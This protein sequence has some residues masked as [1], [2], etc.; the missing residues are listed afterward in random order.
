MNVVK[1]IA[2]GVGTLLALPYLLCYA[3]CRIGIGEQHAFVLTA[4]AIAKIAGVFG[5]YAR[6]AY[7]HR[8]LAGVGCDVY[9]GFMSLFS[10]TQTIIGDRVYIG[11]F[12][13]IGYARLEDDVM[14]A[15]GVQVLSGQ[16]QHGAH[17]IRGQPLR[18][19]PQQYE[20]VTIGKGAWVGAGAIVMADVGSCAVVGAGAVVVKPVPV[21][22]K[23]A[24]V[25]AKAISVQPRHQ[26]SPSVDE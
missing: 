1:T 26:P 20:I 8:M 3:L 17:S 16:R 9:F 6:Q 10:K 2:R 21:G 4:E 11:R 15:D 24:G 22:G 7:Y 5:V 12:C 23:V 19:N 18:D 13:V 14:L 25:P